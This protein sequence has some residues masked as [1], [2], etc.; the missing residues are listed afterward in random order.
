MS[1]IDVSVVWGPTVLGR[2]RLG[3]GCWAY[4]IAAPFDMP[5]KIPDLIGMRVSFD[6]RQFEVRGSIPK[7]PPAPIATGELMVLLVL[8]LE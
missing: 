3:N 4:A 5:Q 6:G 8:A 2:E 1:K 7:M